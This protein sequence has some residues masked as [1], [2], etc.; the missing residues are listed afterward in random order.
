MGVRVIDFG[1]EVSEYIEANE[2]KENE[3]TLDILDTEN[4]RVVATFQ[5][6]VWARVEAYEEDDE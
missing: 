1:A 3:H 5:N 4:S 2:W 6:R